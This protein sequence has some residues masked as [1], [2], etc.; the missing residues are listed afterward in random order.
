MVRECR[1]DKWLLHD[2][3]G[4]PC[5]KRITTAAAPRS[6]L[7]LHLRNVSYDGILQLGTPSDT[8][9]VSY[10]DDDMAVTVARDKRKARFKISLMMKRVT[11]WLQLRPRARS[12]QRRTELIFLTKEQKAAFDSIQKMEMNDKEIETTEVTKYLGIPLD[13]QMNVGE[14]IGRA[15]QKVEAAITTLSR[16]MASIGECQWPTVFCCTAQTCGVT[17]WRSNCKKHL[18]LSYSA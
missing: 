15:A 9:L 3:A 14:D 10:A 12:R 11:E 17:L 5:R 6:I 7:Q 1:K 2:T 8:Y 4:R 16:L 18:W 13:S